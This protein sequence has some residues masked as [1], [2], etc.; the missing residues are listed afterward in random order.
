[1]DML[2]ASAAIGALSLLAGAAWA[3]PVIVADSVADF[4]GAQGFN[5]WH[6]GW[7]NLEDVSLSP[8]V[9]VNNA[10]FRAFEFYDAGTG[11]WAMDPSSAGGD[12]NGG[13]TPGS[14][15]VVTAAL[16]HPNAPF[17]A[18]N[19]VAEEQW[20]VRRWVSTLSGQ[21]TLDGIVRHQDYGMPMVGNGTIAHILVDGVSVFAY[22]VALMDFDGTAFSFDLDVVEGTVIEMAL[23]SKGDPLFDATEFRMQVS[24]LVPAPGA[25]ALLGFG[26]LLVGGRRRR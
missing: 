14:Y 3:E 10:D 1:M 19:V 21:V 13:A 24:T 4:G 7:Y 23:G 16:M 26:G 2:R 25:A 22:D 11:W 8:T 18:G 15:A 20:S 9:S 5:G 12:P 6:Y 17:A